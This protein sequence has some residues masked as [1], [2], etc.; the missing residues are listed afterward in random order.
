MRPPM[1]RIIPG[2]TILENRTG[3]PGTKC[4]GVLAVQI[5]SCT[6]VHPL[7]LTIGAVFD[8]DEKYILTHY[9]TDARGD[10][11]LRLSN[12]VIAGMQHCIV[13]NLPYFTRISK[14]NQASQRFWD[15]NCI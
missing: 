2:F 15:D 1:T 6:S 11:Y 13:L 5:R 9:P 8:L 3:H 14:K 7:H 12:S 10:S 4:T